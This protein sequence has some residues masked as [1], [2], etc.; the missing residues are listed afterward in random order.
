MKNGIGAQ[1]FACSNNVD[2]SKA[3]F[4]KNANI[5]SCSLTTSN[6]DT[7]SLE[8]TTSRNGCTYTSRNVGDVMKVSLPMVDTAATAKTYV[9]VTP[10]KF[11]VLICWHKPLTGLQWVYSEKDIA[12]GNDFETLFTNKTLQ[13]NTLAD[14]DI[15]VAS[16][17][18][19]QI[20][21]VKLGYK[22]FALELKNKM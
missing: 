17:V 8:L 13:S 21:E 14:I 12:V 19:N 1:T 4:T 16:Q 15:T 9:T 22:N 10:Y 6:D 20:S 18:I 11:H 5:F 2:Y 7:C 3:A